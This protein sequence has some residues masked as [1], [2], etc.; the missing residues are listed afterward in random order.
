MSNSIV[1]EEKA[2]EALPTSVA[3]PVG[4]ACVVPPRATTSCSTSTGKTGYY[5][6]WVN[7][8]ELMLVESG[9][10]APGAIDARTRRNADEPV[11][12]PGIPEPHQPGYISKAFGPCRKIAQPPRFD[13]TIEIFDDYLQDKENA[14]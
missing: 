7:A 4:A 6:H 1:H 10:I 13:V 8:T 14:A 11:E 5:G 12:E 2:C 9:I 3:P